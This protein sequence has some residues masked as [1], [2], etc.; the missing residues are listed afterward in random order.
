MYSQPPWAKKGRYSGKRH[1]TKINC[2]WIREKQHCFKQFLHRHRRRYEKEGKNTSCFDTT[3]MKILVLWYQLIFSHSFCDI[4][5]FQFIFYAYEKFST[6]FS[7]Y[8]NGFFFVSASVRGMCKGVRGQTHIHTWW[9]DIVRNISCNRIGVYD[10]IYPGL[11]LISHICLCLLKCLC[12]D[13]EI[14][15]KERKTSSLLYR[16]P[17]IFSLLFF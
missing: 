10:E 4:M 13:M 16:S 17:H 9:I 1:N 3:H 15:T 6:T 11:I 5:H 7:L 12:I 2:L 14:S 8:W